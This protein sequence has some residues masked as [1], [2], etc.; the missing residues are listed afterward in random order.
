M[1]T[2]WYRK[3]VVLATVLGSLAAGLL[4]GWDEVAAGGGCRGRPSTEGTGAAVEM[5]EG[6][7][8]VPTVLH[9]QAGQTV[10]WTNAD[11]AA[12]SVAGAT[13]E[14]GNYTTHPQGESVSYVFERPGTYPY[15]CFEH[16]GMTG[17]IVVGDGRGTGAAS[18]VVAARTAAGATPVAPAAPMKPD[19]G[20][21]DDSLLW[22]G[23]T[24]VVGFVAGGAGVAFARRPR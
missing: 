15:Y 12:H 5:T 21:E 20:G 13:T 7:C 6:S 11:A 16:N 18:L 24:G 22:Y 1:M 17:A 9:V 10:T 3:L 14:W 2:H 23:V 19:N 8:F 4:S